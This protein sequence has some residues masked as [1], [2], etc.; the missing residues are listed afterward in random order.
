MK[1]SRERLYAHIMY[2]RSTGHGIGGLFLY[3]RALPLTY[4]ETTSSSALESKLDVL[5][6]GPINTF[7]RRREQA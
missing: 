1:P 7:Y 5:H 2:C 4:M 3:D 6:Q